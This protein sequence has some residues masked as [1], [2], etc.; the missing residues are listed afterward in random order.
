MDPGPR[1]AAQ[2]RVSN[3]TRGKIDVF[4]IDALV[5]MLTAAGLH[6]DLVVRPAV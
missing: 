2:P 5:N 1:S 3:L 4:R 6:L